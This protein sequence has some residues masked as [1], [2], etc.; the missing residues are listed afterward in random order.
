MFQLSVLSNPPP[1]LPDSRDK[2]RLEALP[3]THALVLDPWLEPLPSPGPV[4]RVE[5]TRDARAPQVLIIN[6]EEFTLWRDH[7]ARLQDVVREWR[8]PNL[9][10]RSREHRYSNADSHSSHSGH[11]ARHEQPAVGEGD[12]G[13]EEPA[14]KLITLIRAKHVSFSDF[15]VIWP[16]G[17]LAP[18]GR[19]LLRIVGDLA[20]AFFGDKLSTAL[21]RLPKRDME[22]QRRSSVKSTPP[23]R[24]KRRLKGAVGDVIVH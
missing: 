18:S 24:R 11:L 5:V 19:I 3:I 20:L 1:A 12:D 22:E 15:S 6:S 16:L 9:G 8:Q 2:E 17:H 21:E 13:S 23:G 7:F 10:S 4:P 14:P